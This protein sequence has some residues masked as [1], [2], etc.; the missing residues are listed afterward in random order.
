M[1]YTEPAALREH[2]GTVAHCLDGKE[3]SRGMGQLL[4][5]GSEQMAQFPG[6]ILAQKLD[7]NSF[8]GKVN[9]APETHYTIFVKGLSA[10]RLASDRKIRFI[11]KKSP[12]SNHI[13][14][15][16]TSQLWVLAP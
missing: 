8:L 6:S 16:V 10:K 11:S 2:L 14:N 15:P 5:Q 12:W 4:S 9:F 1:S 3:A 7:S 13:G